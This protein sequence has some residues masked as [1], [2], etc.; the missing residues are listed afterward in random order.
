MMGIFDKF[1]RSTKEETNEHGKL[2]SLTKVYYADKILISDQQNPAFQVLNDEFSYDTKN[3]SFLADQ[4][5][6]SA[7]A[8]AEIFSKETSFNQNDHLF[9]FFF[10]LYLVLNS[11]LLHENNEISSIIM[12]AM[13][14]KYFG[15]PSHNIVTGQID[16]WMLNEKCFL[17]SIFA[18]LKEKDY[19]RNLALFAH[20]CVSSEVLGLIEALEYAQLLLK[21]IKHTQSTLR[22]AL[23]PR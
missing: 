15:P 3:I 16:L 4:F 23:E 8:N 9:H 12:D 6:Q 2:F 17:S 7:K 5:I 11:A 19:F 22:Q 21:M 1:K 13:H 10:D 14:I 18:I 20:S